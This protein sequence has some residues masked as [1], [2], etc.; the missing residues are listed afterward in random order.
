[1][2]LVLVGTAAMA[3][4]YTVSVSPSVSTVKVGDC[5]Y[6]SGTVKQNGKAASGV[7]IGVQDP[8]KLQSLA[9]VAKTDSNGKFT[10]YPENMCPAKYNNKAGIFNFT[11]YAGS[12]SAVGQ[13]TVSPVNTSVADDSV[14]VNNTSKSTYKV[15]LSVNN[16]DKGTT[17][18]AAG[19][20][21][22]LFTSSQFANS[23]VVA[24]IMDNNSKTLWKST[25]TGTHTYAP[26]K[27]T[28]TPL[29]NPTF[30]SYLFTSSY[31]KDKTLVRTP[32][33]GLKTINDVVNQNISVGGVSFGLKTSAIRGV[34][35]SANLQLSGP[36]ITTET[37]TGLR[38]GCSLSC[39]ASVGVEVCVAFGAKTPVE[40]GYDI[41]CGWS[42][43]VE[44]ATVGASAQLASV[45]LD[46]DMEKK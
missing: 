22:T 32:F 35:T 34:D 39:G 11:F 12:S 46:L 20:Q 10:Y 17:T 41:G 37:F 25:F 33:S 24:T 6:F 5:L 27:T 36:G 38:A 18:V 8:M 45:S 7:S 19:K 4:T 28:P 43:C 14:S 2:G 3:Q 26:P 16:Q 1:M 44:A 21:V 40:L 9:N 13:V 30:S 29:V 23:T 42:C 15:K 31:T